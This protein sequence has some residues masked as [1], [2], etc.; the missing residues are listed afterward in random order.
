MNVDKK[1]LGQRIKS[2]RQSKGLT[3]EE[4][5]KFFDNASKGVI[6]NWEKGSNIPNN[7]R[8]KMIAQFGGITVD[9]LLYGNFQLYC[10]DIFEVAHND[11]MDHFESAKNLDVN[12]PEN[13]MNFFVKVF[14]YVKENMLSYG[15]SDRI[16]HLYW[17]SLSNEIQN[18][19]YSNKGAITY[20]YKELE[21]LKSRLHNYFFTPI[22]L[23]DNSNK[24]P[25][26]KVS[27]TQPIAKRDTTDI[28]LYENLK[29]IISKAQKEV[30][31]L[32][33]MEQE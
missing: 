29:G 4:F 28:E 11:F 32:N 6:S 8:L 10:F 7:A 12:K 24:K 1:A 16:Y 27:I 19:E 33:D 25:G 22:I 5:G 23:K 21:S 31:L 30:D 17:E 26:E 3:M 18:I 20:A 9:E 2:I 14:N 13:R 15:D